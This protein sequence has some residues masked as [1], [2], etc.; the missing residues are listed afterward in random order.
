M[1]GTGYRVH[2]N[3]ITNFKRF[4]SSFLSKKPQNRTPVHHLFMVPPKHYHQIKEGH[5]LCCPMGL[6]VN[7]IL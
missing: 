2:T 6:P 7:Q 1:S 3:N 5:R 4:L